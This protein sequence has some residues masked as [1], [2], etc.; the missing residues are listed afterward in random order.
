MRWPHTALP[1]AV[2]SAPRPPPCLSI[3]PPGS[4]F[5]LSTIRSTCLTDFGFSPQRIVVPS[6]SGPPALPGTAGRPTPQPEPPYTGNSRLACCLGCR[7]GRPEMSPSSLPS[8]SPRTS[9]PRK[10]LLPPLSRPHPRESRPADSESPE[11]PRAPVEQ[12]RGNRSVTNVKLNARATMYVSLHLGKENGSTARSQASLPFEYA[13]GK[14]SVKTKTIN[15]SRTATGFAA[16]A[17]ACCSCYSAHNSNSRGAGSNHE[18][19]RAT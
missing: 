1:L 3:Y 14:A 5:N 19:R 16:A 12:K 7:R 4:L 11:W 13:C 8:L 2:H 6:L 10:L 17:A 9:R 18:Q 15:A